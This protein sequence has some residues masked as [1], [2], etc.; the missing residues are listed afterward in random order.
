LNLIPELQSL[1]ALA[2]SLPDIQV[3]VGEP[4]CLWSF[5]W[6]TRVITTNPEDLVLREPDYCRGLILHEAAHGAITRYGQMVPLD[7]MKS[8]PGLHHLLNVIEDCRIENW[9]QQRFPGCRHWIRLYNDRLLTLPADPCDRA[10][11]AGDPARGFL[12]GLLC[13][14]WRETVPC[15]LHPLSVAAIGEVKPHFQQAIAAFPDPIPP[16]GE[17]VRGLYANHPVAACYRAADRNGEPSAMECIIRM[18]QHRMWTLTWTHIVPT[19][20][21]LLEHPDS[22]PTRRFLKESSGQQSVGPAHEGVPRADNREDEAASPLPGEKTYLAAVARHGGLIESC[23][24]VVLRQLI[25]ASRP[26]TRRF[27]RSGSQLDLRVAM[28]CEADPRQHE[29][30]FQRRNLPAHPDPAFIVIADESTSMQG[31]RSEATFDAVVVLREVCLRLGIPLAILGF[32]SQTRRIQDWDADDTPQTR[33]MVSGLLH[34]LGGSTRLLQALER[35]TDLVS[36][37]PESSQLRIWILSDGEVSDP[38]EVRRKIRGLRLSGI[39]VHGLGLGPDSHELNK[40]ASMARVGIR[41]R[42]LPQV[43]SD[44]LQSQIHA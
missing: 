26:K 1:A 32:G 38:D 11:L 42:D 9:L 7:L 16:T 23:A 29:R 4:G 18:T 15:E 30:L 31:E 41:P 43:F 12:L 25:E 37:L 40:V 17:K 22:E 24:E 13:D 5:N 35:A 6:P 14:W 20:R 27:H 8:E 28:Q 2:S 3:V 36:R 33:R 21:K 10:R 34:P 44:L 39:P 19:F